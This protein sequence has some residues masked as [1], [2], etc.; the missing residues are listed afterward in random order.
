MSDSTSHSVYHPVYPHDPI[1]EIAQDVFMVRGSLKMNALLRISRNMAVIRHDSELTLVNPVRLHAAEEENLQTLGTIKHV[2]RLGPMHGID[3]PYYVNTFQAAFWCQPGGSIYTQPTIDVEMQPDG[4]LPFPDAE[5]FCF[6]DTVQPE[7][8]L[9]LQRGSGL[10][11]TCDALQH[12]GD[13]KHNNLPAR[14]ILPLLGFPKTTL[15]GP[16]WLKRMTPADAS[17]KRE[18]ERLLTQDFDALLS[19]HGSFLAHEAKAAVRAA[20][21]RAFP[22]G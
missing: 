19:A 20:I 17:L 5:L 15:V 4:P 3:D 1:E 12:Y 14:L 22:D 16:V 7:A 13:Y 9:V 2:M 10:L 21:E 8:A 11:L 6:N 18:F